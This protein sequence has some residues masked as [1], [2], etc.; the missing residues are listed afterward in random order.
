MTNR[1]GIRYWT[2]RLGF[3]EGK[4]AFMEND[5]QEM[6]HFTSVGF[7]AKVCILREG[8]THK[9]TWLVFGLKFVVIVGSNQ[10]ET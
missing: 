4:V 9:Y 7:E 5:M 6:K 2:A 1:G 10:V 8:I 3:L